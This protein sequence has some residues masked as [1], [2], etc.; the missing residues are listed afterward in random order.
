MSDQTDELEGLLREKEELVEALTQ[1]LEQA[2]E[3]L[4]RMQRSGADRPGSGGSRGGGVPGE[5]VEK[6]SELCEQLSG[7]VSQWEDMQCAPTL[8]RIESQIIELRDLITTATTQGGL[9]AGSASGGQSQSVETSPPSPANIEA[10]DENASVTAGWEAMKASLM[11]SNPDSQAPRAPNVPDHP[12]D[13][14]DDPFASPPQS[15]GEQDS[16]S[17]PEDFESPQPIDVEQATVEQLRTAVHQRDEFIAVILRRYRSLE[18]SRRPSDDWKQLEAAPDDMIR[19]LQELE[20]RLD[21]ACRLAEVELSVERARLG[22]EENRLRQLE[23]NAQKAL[24]R[25]GLAEADGLTVP[26]G[27]SG[28]DSERRWLRMLGIKSEAD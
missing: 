2:A 21:E 6:Q 28:S 3:Q 5:L 23:A 18:Q 25:L 14:F 8:G 11:G 12:L 16:P 1:R 19:R 17:P 4:D 9:I 7:A 27:D 15:I 20:A 13:D 26:E 22:R 24:E 10:G